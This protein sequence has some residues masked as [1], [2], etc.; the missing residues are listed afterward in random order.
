[1]RSLFLALLLVL[2]VVPPLAAQ[3]V[4]THGLSTSKTLDGIT[5]IVIR[6]P[7]THMLVTTRPGDTVDIQGA[8]SAETPTGL[9]EQCGLKEEVEGEVLTISPAYPEGENRS[10]LKKNCWYD[11]EVTLPPDRDA[12]LQLGMG[13][14]TVTGPFTGN[15]VVKMRKGEITL[16]QGEPGVH[17]LEAKAIFGKV[18]SK[19]EDVL[20]RPFF[21]LGKRVFILNPEGKG[22]VYVRTTFGTITVM[23]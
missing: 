4:Q 21:P 1:M 8:V 19:I 6:A 20:P 11:I 17:D 3:A 18:V 22:R 5:L 9:I 14:L 13:S 23:E 2:L 12:R 10:F 7:K 15:F 16:R